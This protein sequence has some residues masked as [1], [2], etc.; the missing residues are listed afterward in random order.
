MKFTLSLALASTLVVCPLAAQVTPMPGADLKAI[1]AADAKIEKLAGDMKFT[2]GPVWIPAKKRLVF[3]DIP[4]AKLMQWSAADGLKPYR[5]SENAN[6]NTLD[7]QGL[8]LSC[9][10]SGRNLVRE[11]TDGKL[12]VIVA[13]HDGKKFN[14]PNDLVVKS[15]GSIYFTDPPY[16]LPKGQA[17]EAEG[18]FVYRL[19]PDGKTTSIVN[20]EFDMPNGVAFSPD[21]TKLYIADSG[22][23]KRVG[24]FPVKEDGSLGEALYWMAGGADGIR[25]DA[26]GNLYTTAGDGVRIY[27]PQGKQLGVIKFPETPANCAFGG[28]DFKTLFVTARTGLYSVALKVPGAKLL[29]AKPAPEK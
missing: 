29:T 26:A 28:E 19:A 5:D 22:S 27:D 8:L 21:E 20:K 23:K 9:Q 17:K 4:A 6:G 14:S 13:S 3:S 1:V 2:E 24:A 12:T 18:N 25:C 16:G 15:D 11:E 10:H 7:A